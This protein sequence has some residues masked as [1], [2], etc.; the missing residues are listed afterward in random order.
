[1]FDSES[2]FSMQDLP[3]PWFVLRPDGRILSSSTRHS[4][5]SSED[6]SQTNI[7]K[8][9]SAHS[10]DELV[11]SMDALKP[12]ESDSNLVLEAKY[13]IGSR[14]TSKM[15]FGYLS[16]LAANRFLLIFVEPGLGV[17][18]LYD[19]HQE[20]EDQ[21]HKIENEYG[22]VRSMLTALRNFF[23]SF[24]QNSIQVDRFGRYTLIKDRERLLFRTDK[25]LS[26]VFW[27]DIVPKIS[28]ELWSLV[29]KSQ[30]NQSV[31]TAE[32]LL[33]EDSKSSSWVRVSSLFGQHYSFVS[34]VDITDS[35]KR[36][37]KLMR[38]ERLSTI[39][40]LAG[41]LAHQYNNL[42]HA[43]L[44]HI[45][46][47]LDEEGLEQKKLLNSAAS[48][49]KSGSN[50]S[51][52]LLSQ[53]RQTDGN[54][55]EQNVEDAMERLELLTKDELIRLKCEL[56]VTV[57][58]AN[59]NCNSTNLDQ[60]LVNLVLNGAQACYATDRKGKVRVTGN[61]QGACYRFKIE[62]NGSGVRGADVAK[63]FTPLFSTKG[64]YASKG[65]KLAEIKGTGLGLSLA[66][67]LALEMGG[68]L[69][70]S[71]TSK[72]GS[73]FVFKVLMSEKPQLSESA[74]SKKTLPAAIE[75]KKVYIADDSLENRMILKVYLK[76]LASGV[77][78]KSN[79]CVDSAEM[80]EFDPQVIFV[81]WLMPE[82]SGQDFLTFLSESDELNK[83]LSR[84]WILS[85]LEDNEE[86]ASWT[87]KIAGRLRKPISQD[88]LIETIG[89]K[90]I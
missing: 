32:L 53:L 54:Q 19:S 69:E 47:A 48:L 7:K 4:Q 3:F 66:G 20:S 8:I 45:H 23:R 75:K 24:P 59:L 44:G 60:V 77:L 76:N 38:D 78:E 43:V 79:G 74:K 90:K 49:L 34:Y 82:F 62:D 9:I 51:Q 22:E 28:N 42:H 31:A 84:T 27:Q 65:S 35:K 89:S 71:E 17:Q 10:W 50:L 30:I 70:L 63:L 58:P 25:D 1:M 85:G 64:V 21:K 16:H 52:S 61:V 56:E 72:Q 55:S 57:E 46:M 36:L 86:L 67:Q 81:D 73:A 41:G 11:L 13:V 29:R 80:L 83:Y 2:T 88:K 68:D 6:F 87:D 33:N 37:E 18:K 15:Y 26:G 14:S 40:V 12:L 39:G 5:I